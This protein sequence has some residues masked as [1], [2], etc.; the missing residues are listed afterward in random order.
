MFFA[1]LIVDI[2]DNNC[3]TYDFVAKIPDKTGTVMR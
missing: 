1:I 3:I 2:A